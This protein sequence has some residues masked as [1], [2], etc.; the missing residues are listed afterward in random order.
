MNKSRRMVR[1]GMSFDLLFDIMSKGYR[2][3]NGIECIEGLPEDVEYLDS[4]VDNYTRILYL[5]F[6]H[7][8]FEDI[9]LGKTIPEMRIVHSI[10]GLSDKTGEEKKLGSE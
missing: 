6:R 5:V 7:P 2:I 4:Y 3:E 10:E 9:E 8:T 1:V